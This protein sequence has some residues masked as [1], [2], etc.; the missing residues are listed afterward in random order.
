MEAPAFVV[1][2]VV[3]GIYE[4]RRVLGAGGMG[5][6]FE[7]H[8]RLL[9]RRVAVK[10]AHTPGRSLRREAQALAAIRHPSMV[11]VYAIGAHQGVEFLVMELVRGTTLYEAMRKQAATE[12]PMPIG[13]AVGLLVGIAEGLSAIHASGISH[14]DVKPANIMLAPGNR[15]VLMDF[16]LFKP[17]FES[18][19][20]VAGSPEYMAPEVCAGRVAPGAGHLVDLYALGV[21]GFELLAGV[22]PFRGDSALATLSLHVHARVPELKAMRSDAPAELAALVHALLAKTPGDRPDDVGEVLGR[23]RAVRARGERT[24]WRDGF[25]V[26]VVDDDRELAETLRE[27]VRAAVPE[28]EVTIAADGEAALASLVKNVPSLL[29]LDLNMPRM[30]GLELCMTLRGAGLA[31]NCRIVSIA[32]ELRPKDREL[33]TRMGVADYVP[34]SPSLPRALVAIVKDAR[35]AR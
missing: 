6:V 21:I 12:Q 1:G 7:A 20:A 2:S 23:L 5:I 9:N 26:L 27:V 35:R 8:D 11:G 4:I 29:L 34:K 25:T 3:G 19:D 13:E 33:L 31:G 22:P 28:A 30:N 10:L 14:R 15:T 18:L 17:E 16:G 24:G 32:G